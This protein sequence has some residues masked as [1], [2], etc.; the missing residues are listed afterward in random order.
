MDKIKK[1]EIENFTCFK[2]AEFN[3]SDGINVLIGQNGTGKTHVL[4]LLYTILYTFEEHNLKK[5][6]FQPSLK[7]HLRY[8]ALLMQIFK[9]NFGSVEN[10][11]ELMSNRLFFNINYKINESALLMTC[12][13]N[14]ENNKIDLNLKKNINTLS[15]TSI[16]LPPQEIL[17]ISTDLIAFCEKYE[18]SHDLTYYNL[19]KALDTPKLKNVGDFQD[20]V[21]DLLQEIGGQIQKK[22]KKFSINFDGKEINAPLLAEGIKKIATVQ[23][24]IENG[25]ITKDTILLWDEP[26][27]HFNPQMIPFLVKLM[28]K[29][30]NAGM[31]IFI[32][33]HDYLLS[34]Q[35]SLRHEYKTTLE[36]KE[37]I[38]DM[39][40]F[41]LYEDENQKEAGILVEEGQDL[42][43]ISNNPILEQFVN[44]H[45]LEHQY[46]NQK[47]QNS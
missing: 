2:K 26:E 40:F 14:I 47:L 25:S 12:K 15:T 36:P 27:V 28:E 22:D 8:V 9:T 3:F 45:N 6:Q 17:S 18:N 34:Q 4:K 32:A 44:H 43:E 37:K 46:F 21:N 1:L 5:L 41:G 35:L 42:V 38:P 24:L 39:K 31:Q 29:M 19:A 7:F 10:I 13:H 16:Y 20:I 23:Y 30:A 33:T 11:I